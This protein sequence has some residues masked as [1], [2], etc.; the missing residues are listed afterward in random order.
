M[1]RP[2]GTED[3]VEQPIALSVFLQHALC[4]RVGLRL[5]VDLTFDIKA[6]LVLGDFSCG[7]AD[8]RSV[9]RAEEAIHKVVILVMPSVIELRQPD[10]INLNVFVH[11]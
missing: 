11:R 8:F 3:V 9:G 7:D 2:N 4:V 10:L 6:T 5:K 1:A